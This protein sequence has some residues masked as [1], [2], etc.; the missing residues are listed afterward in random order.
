MKLNR[1]TLAAGALL[2]TLAWGQAAYAF[3]DT[4]GD[5]QQAKIEALQKAGLV[6]GMDDQSF[7]PK[8]EVTF[9]Q[10]VQ[11]IVN[12]AG[13]NIDNMRFIKEPKASDYFTSVPDDAWYAKAFIVAHHNGLTFPKDVNPNATMSREQFALYL[14]QAIDA[15]GDFPVI[16]TFIMLKDE[17][18]VD[19]AT[20][21]SIQFLL[22]LG[23]AQLDGNKNFR[24]KDVITRSEAAGMIYETDRFLQE[25]GVKN[26]PG[27][28]SGNN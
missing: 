6:S 9:A 20:M 1:K 25:K 2:L 16:M 13:L 21:N 4:A 23:V 28:V 22:K 17:D 26:Q 8:G 24:P 27:P 7:V 5:P 12:G 19:K 11:F 18:K 10:G 3:S 15:K 14:A